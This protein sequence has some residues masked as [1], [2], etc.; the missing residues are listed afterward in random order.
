[1]IN[2]IFSDVNNI[3]SLQNTRKI[4]KLGVKKKIS[5]YKLSQLAKL[6]SDEDINSST[7]D[8]CRLS[9]RSPKSPTS[10]Q[11]D[12]T[13]NN[14]DDVDTN[15]KPASNLENIPAETNRV[16]FIDS[17]RNSTEL[18]CDI[19]Q[20]KSSTD[21]KLDNVRGVMNYTEDDRAS[22]KAKLGEL[23]LKQRL[24][25]EQN[26]RRKEMLAKALADR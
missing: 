1:M 24:M 25:E 21:T 5:P 17:R 7:F 2:I 13:N 10:L 6:P 15:P 19:D 16:N 3:V 11:S 26:K 18:D 20:Q 9:L 4:D 8:K 22:H 12:I 23:Q 14:T